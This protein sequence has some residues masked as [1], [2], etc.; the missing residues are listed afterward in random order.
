M[1]YTVKAKIQ[2]DGDG[3]AASIPSLDVSTASHATLERCLDVLQPMIANKV[4]EDFQSSAAVTARVN[5]M[6]VRVEFEIDVVK[7]HT[8][9]DFS[10]TAEQTRPGPVPGDESPRCAGQ[11]DSPESCPHCENYSSKVTVKESCPRK[12]ELLFRGGHLTGEQL[13]QD[14]KQFG[15]HGFCKKV[16]KLPLGSKALKEA[17]DRVNSKATK[18]KIDKLMK[19]PAT[20]DAAVKALQKATDKIQDDAMHAGDPCHGCEGADRC[21]LAEPRDNCLADLL[22]RETTAETKV[23]SKKKGGKHAPK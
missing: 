10:T 2:K 23:A 17:A 19:D 20:K 18:K 16:A 11:P 21:T 8:L 7:D 4:R 9:S 13:I 1:P 5:A 3:W 22:E 12:D 6:A 14:A 15:C